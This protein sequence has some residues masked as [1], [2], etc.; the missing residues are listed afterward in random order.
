ME[1]KKNAISNRVVQIK[2]ARNQFVLDLFGGGAERFEISLAA[3]QD[4]G[5]DPAFVTG[6]EHNKY[7]FK[8]KLFNY[9]WYPSNTQKTCLPQA[10]C[11]LP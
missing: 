8:F 7:G 2:L 6:V 3:L 4:M 9:S 10:G 5:F 11:C 1:R